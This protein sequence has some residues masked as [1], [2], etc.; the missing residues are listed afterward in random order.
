MNLGGPEDQKQLVS[1]CAK[2]YLFNLVYIANEEDQGGFD[3]PLEPKYVALAPHIDSLLESQVL[4][5]ADYEEDG[6]QG[7]ELVPGEGSQ[8]YLD[9]LIK[10]SSDFLDQKLVGLDRVRQAYYLAMNEGK[11]SRLSEKDRPWYESLVD[12]D[13]YKSLVP[14]DELLSKEE[15]SMPEEAKKEDPLAPLP[16]EEAPEPS[17]SEPSPRDFRE[18]DDS[19]IDIQSFEPEVE[20]PSRTY[21]YKKPTMIWG[22]VTVLT[23]LLGGTT[24]AFWMILSVLSALTA[25]FFA[26]KKVSISG[27]GLEVKSL[28]GTTRMS[29]EDI[30]ETQLVEEGG[31][32]KSIKIISRQG[33]SVE[34]SKWLDDLSGAVHILK[35]LKQSS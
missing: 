18:G 31:E 3:H 22:G 20:M 1:E 17:F 21:L 5:V 23:V 27:D 14:E 9:E 25:V 19:A 28:L 10:T 8:A 15:E 24:S 12:F 13:F 29:I 16:V 4:K 2:T 33:D 32:P 26:G 7:Q 35:R 11:L 30:D 6:E 34:L